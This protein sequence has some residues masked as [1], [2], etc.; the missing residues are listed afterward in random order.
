MDRRSFSV[1]SALT[2]RPPAP[3]LPKARTLPPASSPSPTMARSTQTARPWA[4][5]GPGATTTASYDWDKAYRFCS[6]EVYGGNTGGQPCFFPFVYQGRT[7]HT[8]ITEWSHRA[9]PWCT[10]TANYDM[11][12]DGLEAR[13]TCHCFPGPA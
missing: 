6:E 9:K 7:F 2:T 1:C 11:D 4:A 5:A 12:T 8:C 10:A 3:L 13:G